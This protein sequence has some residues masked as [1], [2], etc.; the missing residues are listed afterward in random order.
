MYTR[1][2][3]LKGGVK[4]PL[5]A[6]PAAYHVKPGRPPFAPL[7][8]QVVPAPQ[9]RPNAATNA[10]KLHQMRVNKSEKNKKKTNNNNNANYGNVWPVNTTKWSIP[11]GNRNEPDNSMKAFNKPVMTDTERKKY[12]NA[13]NTYFRPAG[14]F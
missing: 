11:V 14:V 6:G 3:K 7:P 4:P 9:K 1:K 12:H 13:W 2:N 5:W 10:W 8:Q